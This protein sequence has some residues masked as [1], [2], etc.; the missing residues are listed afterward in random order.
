MED[1]IEIPSG[2]GRVALIAEEDQGKVEAIGWYASEVDEGRHYAV[3]TVE[4]RLVYL[5]RL[6]LN[7]PP[8]VRVDHRNGDELDNRRANLRLPTQSQ[9]AATAKRRRHS[10]RG[11]KGVSLHQRIAAKGGPRPRQAASRVIGKQ[12]H[13]RVFATKV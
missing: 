9:N 8:K 12:P 11:Y 5:H 6:I 4:G 1:V 13:L 7:A 3:A 10:T 2:G